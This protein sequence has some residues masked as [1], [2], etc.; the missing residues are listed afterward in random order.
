M[1]NK[2]W[3]KFEQTGKITD[4]LNYIKMEQKENNEGDNS[5]NGDNSQ[6]TCNKRES[7]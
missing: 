6:W 5:Q 4:Y 2:Y 1:E 3:L 7:L